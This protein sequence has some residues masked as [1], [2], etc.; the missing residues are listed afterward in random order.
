M[1]DTGFDSK[2]KYMFTQKRFI[3]LKSVS[4][5]LFA[6]ALIVGGFFIS[7]A[8]KISAEVVESLS[9]QD[10]GV[11]NE[12]GVR[13]YSAGFNLTDA[14]LA[15]TTQMVVK[16]YSGDTLL[17]T[18][19]STGKLAVD[20]P[21]ATSL[22]GPFDVLGSFD[23][24][25]DTYW[26]NVREGEYGK[27]LVPTK[28]VATVTLS[29]GIT[30]SAINTNLTGDT[31]TIVPVTVL[32][33]NTEELAAAINSQDDGQTWKISAGNYGLDKINNLNVE[34]QT[35]WYFPITANNLTIEGIG[36]PV[37]YGNEFSINGIWSSQN[38]ISIFGDN[39]TIKGLTLM[40]K[41]EGNKTIEVI[42]KDVTIED[43][44]IQPNTIIDSSVY[45]GIIN[46]EDRAFS[47]EWGGSIYFN[48][49]GNHSVK[50]TT[51]VNGGIS[52]RYSP[53]NTHINFDNVNLIYKTA[54]NDVNGYRFSSAFN[55]P[56]TSITGSPMVT[57]Q[58]NSELN[59]LATVLA[60]V[61]DGDTIELTS[62][63][64]TTSQLT[65]N[66]AI[67]IDGQGYKLSPLFTKT[68]GSNNSAIGIQSS[69]V[70]I[71]NLVE[72][73]IGSTALHGINVYMS[74]NV[75]LEDVTVK[76]N[77]RSGIIVN[78]SSVTASDLN[79]T[80]NSWNS[81][82][83]DP[84]S[85]VTTPS[86]FTLNSGTL[87]EKYQIWSDGTNVN[88]IATVIV[89]A[90][91]YTPYSVT[92]GTLWSNKSKA[93]TNFSIENQVGSTKISEVNHTVSLIMPFGTDVTALIPTISQSGESVSPLSGAVQDF[94]TPVIYT[95]KAVDT[96]T[97]EYTVTVTIAEA[98]Q[99]NS[100]GSSNK[101]SGSSR[102]E[103]TPIAQVTPV[104][105]PAAVGQVLG[106]EAFN[107]TLRLAIGSK[108]NEVMELQKF[109]N[110][111]NFGPLVVDGKF[112]PLTKAAVIKFQ[113]SKE[114]KGDGIVGPLTRAVLNK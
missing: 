14:T 101:R 73:G 54:N 72:D 38:L 7:N 109:L 6:L 108:G 22:S 13:G 40:P 37:I 21:T 47:K 88:E 103:V 26:T 57:Y 87:E 63:I 112:G 34:G 74:Q 83:V 36:N 11:W 66:K 68:D 114:L 92:G 80:G 77:G 100:N 23:Y 86:E 75:I 70:T 96:T 82:N 58:V 76:N 104:V 60:K 48:H 55:N 15:D 27:N 35:G 30:L 81:V 49:E 3:N 8:T 90:A 71:K 28:V 2:I 17:Q 78:G 94:T 20:Y 113:V 32:I 43:V 12:S 93:I 79:T 4:T 62:D 61:K 106:A 53:A 1:A 65:I 98:P 19:T 42:G 25:A 10:F 85:G 45:D 69:N 29:N 5:V 33:T 59:N 99:S 91:E 97:A 107:F 102:T 51:I 84:G 44:T 24:A 46:L 52:F 56:D 95:V 89:N 9:T 39:V 18:N 16:L 111:A 31:T 50:D 105:T 67:K 64:T 110:A 41:A